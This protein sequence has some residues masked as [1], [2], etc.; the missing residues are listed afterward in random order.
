MPKKI[1]IRQAPLQTVLD[2][3]GKIPEFKGA[4]YDLDVFEERLKGKNHLISVGFVDE[5]PAGYMASYERWE[6]GSI[7]C[8]MAGVDPEF[9]RHGI[10]TRLMAT[11]GKWAKE[12]GYK[13]ITIKTRNNR[14]E[15]LAFL[16]KNGFNFT[17]IKPKSRIEENRI[18]LEK[19]L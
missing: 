18:M 11:L 17:H 4:G 10:M 5:V 2:V 14:R 19:S 7:Y 6:D 16:V 13:K 8:W 15:M 1:L 9:R 12:K 3:H